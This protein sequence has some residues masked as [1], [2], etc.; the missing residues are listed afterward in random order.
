MALDTDGNLHFW[1]SYLGDATFPDTQYGLDVVQIAA[2]PSVSL[3]LLRDGSITAWGT[4]SDSVPTGNSFLAIAAGSGF[5]LALESSPV[6]EPTSLAIWS[7]IALGGLGMA[8]RRRR[9]QAA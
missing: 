7:A 5:G 4:H 6:P 8:Y 1:G 9:K 3:A 2:G